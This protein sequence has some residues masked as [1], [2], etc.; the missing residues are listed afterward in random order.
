MVVKKGPRGPFL[1]C[2]GY[3]SCRNAKPLPAELKDKVAAMM[4]AAKKAAPAIEVKETCPECGSAM[5]LR[6]GRGGSYFL[7]C[8][9][10]PKC[11]GTREL[12]EELLEQVSNLAGMN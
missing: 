1:S 4:P 12:S 10:Y 6:T 11:K 8:S 7:G 2:S 9:K 3:P 5:K